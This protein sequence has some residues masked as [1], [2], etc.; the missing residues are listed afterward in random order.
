MTTTNKK[1]CRMDMKDEGSIITLLR[2]IVNLIEL[3]AINF[4]NKSHIYLIEHLILSMR[5]LSFFAKKYSNE[6]NDEDMQIKIDNIKKIRDAICHRSSD[7][8]WLGNSIKIQGCLLFH[9]NIDD[10]VIQYGETR[11]YLISDII[12][13]FS[14]FKKIF[15]DSS[16]QYTI[17]GSLYGHEIEETKFKNSIEKLIEAIKYEISNT[18]KNT[19]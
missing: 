2:D 12:D 3:I 19:Y 15:F 13:L 7:N 14:K 5:E 10:V 16:S 17:H 8:N 9:H 4:S 6:K 11:I 1:E 18:Q